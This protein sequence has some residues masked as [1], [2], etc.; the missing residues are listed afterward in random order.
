M[1]PKKDHNKLG[2]WN[3]I[4]DFIAR[5]I[6]VS[7]PS[8]ICLKLIILANNGKIRSYSPLLSVF[9]YLLCFNYM[10]FSLHHQ[11]STCNPN[12]FNDDYRAEALTF[13]KQSLPTRRINCTGLKVINKLDESCSDKFFT[14][15]RR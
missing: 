9:C 11:I 1:L 15:M 2:G 14:D 13:S 5:N 6:K 7:P 12:C 10:T 4:E 8:C 3:V